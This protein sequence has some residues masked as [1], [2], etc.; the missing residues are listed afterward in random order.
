MK[1]IAC[2]KLIRPT[3]WLKNLMVYFPL[4]LSG[5]LIQSISLTAVLP[6][7][8]FCCASSAGYVFNDLIDH[9]R[10]A[11]HPVK[12]SRPIPAG[13]VAV[14]HAWLLAVSLF[15]MSVVM[16]L[17]VSGMFLLF[18]LAYLV[19]MT[20]YSIFLKE[21]AVLDMFCV[22]L[23]FILRLYGGGV[24]FKIQIS[25]WLF[26][27]VF[28][29]S[30]FLSVGKRYG[31]MRILGN[32]AGIHRRTLEEYPRGFLEG[33]MYMS[34]AAVMVTYAL[35]AINHPPM[36]YS[37]PLCM[38]GLLR[39]LMRIKRGA[40][41]DPTESLLKDFPLLATSFLWVI[42]VAWSVYL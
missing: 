30:I 17:N 6:F 14:S 39:Y 29:L 18:I 21:I 11:A 36:V 33:T 7:A 25:D 34:G 35:Y 23:G 4:F 31:E 13:L 5:S 27:T 28:L 40:S 42:F 20:C 38:F 12:R 2:L 32:D 24:A 15:V 16:S 10:D 26:L 1:L 8:A 9:K 41:G 3:H 19:A 22:A 37:V